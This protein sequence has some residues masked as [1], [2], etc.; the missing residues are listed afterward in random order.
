MCLLSWV[1]FNC[2]S[3]SFALFGSVNVCQTLCSFIVVTYIHLYKDLCFFFIYNLEEKRKNEIKFK[4]RRN[5]IYQIFVHKCFSQSSS[6]QL[7]R[8]VSLLLYWYYEIKIV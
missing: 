1:C 2:T 6:F 4:L 7:D 3:V 5:L 8:R